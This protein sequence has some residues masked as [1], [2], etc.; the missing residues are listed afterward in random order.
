MRLRY[1][2]NVDN[3]VYD[4][5]GNGGGTLKHKDGKLAVDGNI[6]RHGNDL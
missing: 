1:E 3:I 6:E 4:G 2:E 5:G